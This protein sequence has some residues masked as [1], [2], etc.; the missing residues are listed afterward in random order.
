MS[1]QCG[2]AQPTGMS[3]P[4]TW[5]PILAACIPV[6]VAAQGVEAPSRYDGRR[7]RPSIVSGT[8]Y[9]VRGADTVQTG[10]YALE[11]TVYEDRILFV[12]SS[13]TRLYG[14]IVD[15]IIDS[16]PDLQPIA[17]YERSRFG[18]S[19]VDFRGAQATGSYTRPDGTLN[20]SSRPTG[21]AASWR[22]YGNEGWMRRNEGRIGSDSD[23]HPTCPGATRYDGEHALRRHMLPRR[24]LN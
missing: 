10:S 5:I 9:A 13:L 20:T 7:L 12:N 21:I 14:E 6:T 17:Y 24:R 11:L 8:V 2:R 22:V 3:K 4:S 15:T 16:L 18:I 23:S 19:R 1:T